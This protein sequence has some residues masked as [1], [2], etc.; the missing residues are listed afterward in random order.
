MNPE[1]PTFNVDPSEL[2]TMYSTR[3]AVESALNFQEELSGLKPNLREI[4]ICEFN[5]V[6]DRIYESSEGDLSRVDI[7]DE[8]HYVEG[9]RQPHIY[10]V[11]T[12]QPHN[13]IFDLD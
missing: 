3:D 1:K 8:D 13:I 12:D 7:K 9:K 5:A 11:L 6:L 10:T 2:T 4:T